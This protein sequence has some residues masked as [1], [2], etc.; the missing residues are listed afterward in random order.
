[1]KPKDERAL[2]ADLRSI[3]IFFGEKPSH[4]AN[5]EE[6]LISSLDLAAEDAKILY[7]LANWIDSYA[8]LIHTE[9]LVFLIKNRSLPLRSLM[10]LGGFCRHGARTARKLQLV[11]NTIHKRVR[12]IDKIP[13]AEHIELPVVIGQCEANPDF[14][15]FGLTVAPII[16]QRDKILPLDLTAKM[17]LHIR[18]R[19]LFGASWRAEIATYLLL[20]GE[21]TFY[22][23]RKDLGCTNETALRI[24]KQLRLIQALGKPLW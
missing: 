15:E 24:G 18:M 17:N 2:L 5:P 6:T 23:L 22:R 10:L 13:L 11:C 20:N 16:D 21:T 12:K 9:R 19:L 8:D 7:L 4:N 1:M 3:G 14:K